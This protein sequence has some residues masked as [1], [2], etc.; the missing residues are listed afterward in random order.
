LPFGF[1]GYPAPAT[2]A[3]NLLTNG[4][5]E[6]TTLF[7]PSTVGITGLDRNSRI[8]YSEQ[9]SLEIDREIGKGLVLSAGYLFVVAHKLVRPVNLNVCPSAGGSDGPFSCPSA[10]DAFEAG[11]NAGVLPIASDNTIDL[12]GLVG[13]KSAF[14]GPLYP[15]GLL[16]FLDNS[17]N[18]VY[19]GLTFSVTERAG[20]YLRLNANYT[21]SRTLDDG[22]FTT[23]VSTPQDLYQRE[24][25]RANSNQDVRHRFVANFVAYGPENTFARHFEFSSIITAQ[26]ARPFTMFFG[27]DGNGDTNPVTDR[28]GLSARNAYWGDRLITWDLR[29]SRHFK[30]GERQRIEVAVDAFN[31]LNRANVNEVTSV[32]GAPFF[33]A[34]VPNHYKDGITSPANPDFGG[35]R[36]MFNPRQFQFSVKYSF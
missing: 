9:A 30:F 14:S 32:Y 26:S 13:I 25:E 31:V 35:P 29:L 11:T 27:A 2:V 7:P 18:S 21:F 6:P 19:H 8:P 23:F 34:G 33:L 10:F 16:Y 5:F 24:L 17:G 1:P 36:T 15:A 12:P 22:T 20:N 28:V 3:S 4:T